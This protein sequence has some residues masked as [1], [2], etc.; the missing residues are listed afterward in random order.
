MADLC[1]E[2]II[3]IL[4]HESL[5]FGC[6]AMHINSQSTPPQFL[7]IG[8]YYQP[9]HIQLTNFKDKLNKAQLYLGS[10]FYSA[11]QY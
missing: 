7:V 2:M 3:E 10:T 11:E 6:P 8:S 4:S 9:I 5:L 1:V